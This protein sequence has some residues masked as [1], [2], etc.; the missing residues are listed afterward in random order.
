M[1]VVEKIGEDVLVR[2]GLWRFTGGGEEA[3]GGY[4]TLVS[5]VRIY[6]WGKIGGD[7]LVVVKAQVVVG[8]HWW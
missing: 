7:K 1:A 8:K 5:A 3:A 2:K 4:D 6:W